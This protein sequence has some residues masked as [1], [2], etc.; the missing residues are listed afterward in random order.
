MFKEL[1]EIVKKRL[2]KKVKGNVQIEYDSYNDELTIFITLDYNK[3]C[4]SF[5]NFSRQVLN[6]L[7]SDIIIQQVINDYKKKIISLYLK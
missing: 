2:I 5:F 3:Y 6:G 7:T 1:I 4:Y